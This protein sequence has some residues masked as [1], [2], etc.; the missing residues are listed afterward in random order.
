MEEGAGQMFLGSFFLLESNHLF[1]GGF[2]VV[3]LFPCSSRDE[4]KI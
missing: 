3:S 1:G 2:T 4:R